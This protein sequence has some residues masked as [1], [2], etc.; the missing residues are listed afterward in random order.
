LAETTID[1]ILGGRVTIVQPAQGYRTAIDPVLLAA[2]IPA[3]AGEAVLDAGSGTGAASLALAARCDGARVTGLEAQGPL[4]A[5]ARDSAAQSGLDGRVRFLEGDLLAPPEELAVGS[6]DHV[7][8]NPPYIAA[9]QGNP[10]PDAG[11]RAAT[12]EGEAVLM[13]WLEFLLSRVR[14]GGTVTVIHR[15]DR[16]QEITAGLSKGGAGGI[17]VLPLL[18][19]AGK[20]AKRVIVQARKGDLGD[21]R[22]ADGL[23]LHE[24]DGGYTPAAEAILRGT[25]ALSL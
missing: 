11:K 17:K 22:T 23:I 16:T 21:I 5:L 7:M 1:T 25:K 12:V 6:F 13:D 8:A 14:D 9:G 2:A 24:A 4:V 20:A 18:P 19:H 15:F 3:N 10:P